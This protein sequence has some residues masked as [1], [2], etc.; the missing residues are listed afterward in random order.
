MDVR[1]A[2][3]LVLIVSAL[4]PAHAAVLTGVVV[5]NHAGG[6]GMDNVPIS[7]DE[8]GAGNST[9]SKDGGKFTLNISDKRP[10]ETVHVRVSESG[11]T[12]IDGVQPE[13]VL[14]ANPEANRLTIIL[15]PEAERE[16]WA[17]L[18]YRVTSDKTI[19][20]TY[21]EKLRS[22]E[23]EHRA[24]A[25]SLTQL[26][27]ERNQAKAAAEKA[28][29]ALARIP[30]GQGSDRYRQ[31]QRL[32]LDGK[33]AAAIE[34]LDDAKSSRPAARTEPAVGDALP[35][36]LLKAQLLILEFRFEEAGNVYRQAMGVKTGQ[37]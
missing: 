24:D 30:P 28:T 15:C 17:G 14:P 22:L 25:A 7:V 9:T 12:V 20:G 35:A 4:F 5:E 11:Y 1:C 8:A 21:Q 6:P 36:W 23:Q 32:F 3:S 26:Q 29:E 27:Q 37:F 19:E 31:A 33:L 2:A 16:I 10:G 18:L 13:T 34:L